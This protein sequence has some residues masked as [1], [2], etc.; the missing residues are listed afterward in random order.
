MGSLLEQLKQEF[1]EFYPE[2]GSPR[3]FFAPG[4]VNLIGEHTDYTGGFV[5]PM[6]LDLG[7]TMLTAPRKDG[8]FRLRSKSFEQPVEFSIEDLK[9]DSKA[10]KKDTWGNYPKGVVIE[11]LKLGAPV[12]GADILY[13]SN[14]P[15]GAGLSSSAAI[16]MA[17]AFGLAEVAEF[18]VSKQELAFLCQRMENNFIGVKSGIMDQFAVGLSKENHA[19]FIDCTSSEYEYVPFELEDHKVVITNTAK[20]RGLNESRYNERRE[21][22]EEALKQ[23]AEMKP[24]VK[25]YRD[26]SLDDLSLINALRYPYRERARHIVTENHRVLE[27]KAAL[28][29]GNLTQFGQLMLASHSLFPWTT[30][31]PEKSWIP[32]SRYSLRPGAQNPHDRRRLRWLHRQLGKEDEIDQFIEYVRANYKERTGLDPEFYIAKGSGGVREIGEE[33]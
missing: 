15:T 7:I 21:E 10:D 26:L 11:L 9:D 8:V 5:M 2:A 23:I 12:T 4:R 30:K 24:N 33:D 27:A 25:S 19:I 28:E 18:E 29:Q 13:S 17:T 20:K 31:L 22:A 32:S 1:K 3:V 6:A 14:L 16:G